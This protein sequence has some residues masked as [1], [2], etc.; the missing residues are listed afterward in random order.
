MLNKIKKVM[1]LEEVRK[2]KMKNHKNIKQVYD[3][4]YDTEY[5]STLDEDW[6]IENNSDEAKAFLKMN[7][8]EKEHYAH[9]HAKKY[10][11]TMLEW[12]IEFF[13]QM[14]GSEYSD[15]LAEEL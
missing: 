11:D 3:A 6:T 9:K 7:D 12:D 2:M 4:I 10:C 1:T 13:E 15:E 5:F 8:T 14:Y